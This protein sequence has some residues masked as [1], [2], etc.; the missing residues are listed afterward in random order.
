MIRQ[1]EV[2]WIDFPDPFG[3]GPGFRRPGVVIQGD[4]FNASALQTTVVAALTSQMR[5]RDVP[6][7][8]FLSASVTGLPKDSVLL[9]HQIFAIDKNRL[10]EPVD[11][12]PD[13][14]LIR[15]LNAV[16]LVLGRG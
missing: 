12:L 7:N 3:S 15:V 14:Y 11:Q 6:G 13:R 9:G 5:H 16:D 2:W 8:V 10:D 4:P 1:G